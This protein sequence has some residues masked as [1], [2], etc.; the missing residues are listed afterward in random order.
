MKIAI[1]GMGRMGRMVAETARSRGHEIVCT[2]DI[3]NQEDFDSEA[4]RSADV[5]IEFSVPKSAAENVAKCIKRGMPVV[6]G[7]TAWDTASTAE[8]TERMGGRLMV[9]SNFSTGVALFRA[10]CRYATALLEHYPA[11]RPEIIETHHTAK[12]DHPSGTAVTLAND[13]LPLM[14]RLN[15]WEETDSPGEDTL[16][17]EARRIADC[18]G[19]HTLRWDSDAD[20]I[21]ITHTAHGRNGFASGAVDAAE[22]LIGQQPGVYGIDDMYNFDI[23]SK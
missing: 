20:S 16:R 22:W 9:A 12:L 15:R 19:T 18:P 5:A 1:I 7:T 6:C 14:H 10:I 2:I 13:V 3:D 11:Y 23:N 17:V 4:F 8:L 21:E